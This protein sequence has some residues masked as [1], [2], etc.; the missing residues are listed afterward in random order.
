MSPL[1]IFSLRSSSFLLPIV[2]S[3]DREPRK[4]TTLEEPDE[5]S[6]GFEEEIVGKFSR[7]DSVD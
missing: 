1:M 7:R 3:D 6:Q 5:K 4:T 2:S